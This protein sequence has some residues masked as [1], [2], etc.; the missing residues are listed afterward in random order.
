MRRLLY[1][2]SCIAPED[3]SFFFVMHDVDA[4][5]VA[6]ERYIHNCV[7]KV[8][9]HRS[10]DACVSVIKEARRTDDAFYKRV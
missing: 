7:Y 5:G 6:A 3:F 1:T 2:S 9:T 4:D 10:S 8:Y